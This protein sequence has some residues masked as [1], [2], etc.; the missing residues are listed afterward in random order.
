M[1]LSWFRPWGRTSSKGVCEGT[2]LSCTRSA[3]SRGYKRGELGREAPRSLQEKELVEMSA[4]IASVDDWVVDVQK[5][6]PP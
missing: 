4:M 6:V 5:N 2:V 1:G 3:R